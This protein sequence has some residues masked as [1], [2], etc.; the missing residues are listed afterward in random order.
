[1]L[2][3]E[4]AARQLEAALDKREEEDI[5]HQRHEREG[6]HADGRVRDRVGEP[7]PPVHAITS[8]RRCTARTAVTQANVITIS[9]SASR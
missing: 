7:G 6:Q 4:G 1:V 9:T 3:V 8:L 5:D 2:G